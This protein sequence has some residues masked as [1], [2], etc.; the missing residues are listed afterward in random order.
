M[1]GPRGERVT[2]D[3]LNYLNVGLMLLSYM[4]ACWCP[5]ELMVVSYAVLGPLHYLTE[6]AW[7]HKRSYFADDRRQAWWLWGLAIAAFV[8]V[9]IGSKFFAGCSFIA[10]GFALCLVV[11]KS[12]TLRLLTLIFLASCAVPATTGDTSQLIFAMFLTTLIHVFVFTWLFVLFGCLKE[13]RLSGFVSIATFT[14]LAAALLLNMGCPPLMH[15]ASS[16]F[17]QTAKTGFGAMQHSFADL[18]SYFQKNGNDLTAMRFIAFA[19]TYHYLNWLSKTK[20]IKWHEVSR[21]TFVLIVLVYAGSLVLYAIDYKIGLKALFFLSVAHVY[22][23]FPLNW[24][25]MG[26]IASELSRLCSRGQTGSVTVPP[27]SQAAKAPV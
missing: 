9:L 24:R 25:T 6:I 2:G 4:F 11:T 20:V 19:Y 18:C 14:L 21:K 22:L 3:R 10:L 1:C 13:K 27:I 26:G 15:I 23:E 7:L 17:L 8:A 5:I 16:D 12:R